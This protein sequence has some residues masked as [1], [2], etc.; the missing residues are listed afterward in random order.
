[1]NIKY[2]KAKKD[3][4]DLLIRLY[5]ASFYS[6]YVKYGE[7]PAYGKSRASMEES[8]ENIPK[9]IIYCD[10]EPVGAISITDKGNGEYYIGGLCVIP[11]FQGKGIGTQA[12]KYILELHNDWKKV[13]LKTPEDKEENILFYTRK[14]GFRID[15]TQMDGNVKVYYF[16]LER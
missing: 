1:M 5:N 10:D 15:G 9:W 13:T 3:D 11:E 7:C 6:D 8:I 4:A 12:V 14:C 16:V 2:V